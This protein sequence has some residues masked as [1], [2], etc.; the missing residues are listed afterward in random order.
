MNSGFDLGARR[1]RNGVAVGAHPRAAQAVDRREADLGQIERL[2]SQRQQVGL[3]VQHRS[4]DGLHT[5]AQDALP[6]QVRAALQIRVQLVLVARCWNRHPMVAPE[7]SAF[8]F[9]STL[10]VAASRVAELALKA[11]VRTEGD[12]AAGLFPPMAAQDLLDRTREVIVAKQPE[13]PA[14]VT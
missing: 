7:V 6:V 3:L 13:D 1:Q 9:D 2:G 10:L 11:P 4:T 12:E 8:A 14:K 5:P